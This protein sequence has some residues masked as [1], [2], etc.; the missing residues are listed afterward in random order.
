LNLIKE[1][2]SEQNAQRLVETNA[3]I[4]R[5][6]TL[7]ISPLLYTGIDL[8]DD[9]SGF[10]IIVKVPYHDLTDRWIMQKCNVI[11]MVLLAVAANIMIGRNGGGVHYRND[12]TESILLGENIAL[13]ILQEQSLYYHKDDLFKCTL[14][15]DDKKR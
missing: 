12:Y 1:N 9:L 5:D 3:T 6:P 15:K 2:I 13:G 10:Q 8:K 11:T 4:E 7:L 14:T